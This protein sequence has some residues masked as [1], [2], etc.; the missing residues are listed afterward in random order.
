MV[1]TSAGLDGAGASTD[2]ACACRGGSNVGM[3][4]LN[5]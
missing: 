5:F 1:V 3:L 4:Q 2:L